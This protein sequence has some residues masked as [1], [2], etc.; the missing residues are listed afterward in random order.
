MVGF[1]VGGGVVEGQVP[2][3]TDS[4]LPYCPPDLTI[5]PSTV[6]S[7]EPDPS[8]FACFTVFEDKEK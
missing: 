1:G 8:K 7:Y 2:N 3:L 5:V 4:L 6:T